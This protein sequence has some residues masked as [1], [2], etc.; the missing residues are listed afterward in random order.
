[1]FV[2]LC[3]FPLS[4]TPMLRRGPLLGHVPSERS[5]RS[6]A[7]SE[8]SSQWGRVQVAATGDVS[9]GRTWPRGPHWDVVAEVDDVVHSMLR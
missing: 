5:I 9:S 4:A 8:S 2:C 3:V 7:E 1:M 6:R